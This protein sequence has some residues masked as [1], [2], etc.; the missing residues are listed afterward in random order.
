MGIRGL[1]DLEEA[2]G[3]GG[4]GRS[5]RK[6]GNKMSWALFSNDHRLLLLMND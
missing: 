1:W 2:G 4:R 3:A 5:R 6:M